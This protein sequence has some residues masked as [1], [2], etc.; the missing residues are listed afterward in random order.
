MQHLSVLEL[1]VIVQGE[2]E[3]PDPIDGKIED[4][5]NSFTASLHNI[6]DGEFHKWRA[7]LRSSISKDDQNMGQEA[8]R[9][10]AQIY[11]DGHCFNKKEMALSFLD[12]FDTSADLAKE[13]EFF[14]GHN[15]KIS[16]RLFGTNAT[17]LIQKPKTLSSKSNDV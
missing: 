10:W 2:K 1:R 16:V 15:K 3:T 8:D 6:S 7:S 11:T 9:F 12:S 14:R 5:L 13:F 4:V 17:K